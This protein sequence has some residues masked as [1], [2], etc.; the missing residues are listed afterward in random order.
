MRKDCV[1]NELQ[2]YIVQHRENSQCFI[3]TYKRNMTLANGESL[4]FTTLTYV[5]SSSV[6]SS[7]LQP[8]E[9]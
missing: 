9:L 2:G 8:H 4:Y 1:E 3:N 7:S 5:L 6:M